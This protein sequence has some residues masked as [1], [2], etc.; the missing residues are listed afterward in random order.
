[1]GLGGYLAARSDQEHY[2]SEERREYDETKKLREIELEETADIFR[3][4]G[5]EGAVLE[6]VTRAI[7]SDQKRWVDFMMRFELDSNVLIRAALR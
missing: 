6:Q 4:Y 2:G 7:A 5:L 1:M 3:G